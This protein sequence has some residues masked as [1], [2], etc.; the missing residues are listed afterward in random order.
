VKFYQNLA[1]F[2][3]RYAVFDGAG[4][5]VL[6]KNPA[7]RPQLPASALARRAAHFALCGGCAACQAAWDAV[8]NDAKAFGYTSG[9]GEGAE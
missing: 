5:V 2:Q 3:S 8:E 7:L 4:A 6:I 1:E 9:E